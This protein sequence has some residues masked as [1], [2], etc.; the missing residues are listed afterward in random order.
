L[1]QVKQQVVN[2]LKATH[3]TCFWEGMPLEVMKKVAKLFNMCP[4]L[5]VGTTRGR[6]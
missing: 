3:A 4:T 5:V 1:L 2:D 6:W